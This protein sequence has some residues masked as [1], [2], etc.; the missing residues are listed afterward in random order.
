MVEV[1]R[2]TYSE[3][4][5]LTNFTVNRDCSLLNYDAMYNGT[6]YRRFVLCYPED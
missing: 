6:Q 5:V 1:K 4:S 2:A 3:K